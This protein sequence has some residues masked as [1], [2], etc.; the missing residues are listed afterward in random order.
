MI[1]LDAPYTA[2]KID[3]RSTSFLQAQVIGFFFV[4]QKLWSKNSTTS[5]P[6][7]LGV[8]FPQG[9]DKLSHRS[10]GMETKQLGF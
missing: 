1:G 3:M 6:K 7:K 2:L 5:M 8:P 10:T 4:Q 9:D